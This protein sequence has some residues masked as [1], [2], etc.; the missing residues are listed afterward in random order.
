MGPTLA[1]FMDFIR[2][3]MAIDTAVLPDNSP[4]IPFAMS[5]AL[6][7][8]NPAFMCVPPGPFVEGVP[9]ANIYNLMVYNLSASNLLAYA[10]DQVGETYFADLR[11]ELDTNG[12][13]SGVI[14]SSFDDGT[15]NSMVVMEAAKNFTLANLQQLK[16]PWGRTYLGFAQSYGPS[17]VGIT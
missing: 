15:G 17:V 14:Q 6:A 13:V 2:N 5:V 16:D 12:F 3:V 9:R 7:I 10:Q 4:V 11:E 8:V 1:G